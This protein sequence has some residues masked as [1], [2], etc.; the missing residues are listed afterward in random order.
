MGQSVASGELSWGDVFEAEY[1][2][3]QGENK[4]SGSA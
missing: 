1:K 4:S 3:G 2:L